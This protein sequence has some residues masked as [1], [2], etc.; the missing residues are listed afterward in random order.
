MLKE[1]RPETI[2]IGDQILVNMHNIGT[3]VEVG[4]KN[5]MYEFKVKFADDTITYVFHNGMHRE[6]I[7]LVC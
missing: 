4:W 1:V 5:G 3:V 7:H 6:G 2:K